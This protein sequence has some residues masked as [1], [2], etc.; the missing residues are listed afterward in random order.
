MPRTLKPAGDAIHPSFCAQD[1]IM[2]HWRADMHQLVK[3]YHY[4]SAWMILFHHVLLQEQEL[5]VCR[6]TLLP[7]NPFFQKQDMTMHH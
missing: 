2:I 6:I 5:F 7:I 4:Q 1:Y 3:H